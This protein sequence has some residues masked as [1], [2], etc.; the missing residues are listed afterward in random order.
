[1]ERLIIFMVKSS[2]RALEHVLGSYCLRTDMIMFWT[3]HSKQVMN[4]RR[5][6]KGLKSNMVALL[7]WSKD[8]S[9]D[10]I[11]PFARTP[12][13][14]FLSLVA[15]FSWDNDSDDKFHSNGGMLAS[16][17][18]LS[19]LTPFSSQLVPSVALKPR[20]TP[21]PIPGCLTF[22]TISLPLSLFFR[23]LHPFTDP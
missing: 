23:N 14:F 16:Q 6:D 4:R 9:P 21:W 18:S 12:S 11:H 10:D 19:F 2:T 20:W 3:L 1:M 5:K 13:Q 22:P 15:P 7:H 17:Y 8:F